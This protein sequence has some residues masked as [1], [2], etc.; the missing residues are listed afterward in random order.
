MIVSGSGAAQGNTNIISKWGLEVVSSPYLENVK[1][2]GN[3]STGWY[4]FAD[5]AQVDT[6]EIGYLK[7]KRFPTVERGA[8]DLAHFGIGYRVRFDFGIREQDHRGMTFAPGVTV[9]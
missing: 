6:F 8:F 4:L 1:Y 5:P 7:G 2:T 3:S 9:G